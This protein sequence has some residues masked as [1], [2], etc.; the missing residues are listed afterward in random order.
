VKVCVAHDGI[1]RSRRTRTGSQDRALGLETSADGPKSQQRWR[2]G[3]GSLKPWIRLAKDIN[4]G[5]HTSG[6][7]RTPWQGQWR[8][9]EDAWETWRHMHAGSSGGGFLAIMWGDRIL[10]EDSGITVVLATSVNI[11]ICYR[12]AEPN[13]KQWD[14]FAWWTD[15]EPKSPNQTTPIIYAN[16]PKKS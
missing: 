6:L 3:R 13:R 7:R 4:G 10:L 16:M 15:D 12:H 11:V 8:S 9:D 2:G 14:Q 5:A 1:P